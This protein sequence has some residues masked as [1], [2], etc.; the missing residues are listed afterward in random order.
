MR[1]AALSLLLVGCAS[2]PQIPANEFHITVYTQPPGALLYLT[3]SKQ[4]LGRAPQTRAYTLHTP[5]QTHTESITAVWRSGAI[6][7]MRILAT[8]SI[9]NG[10]V[11][12]SRPMHAPGLDK[13]MSTGG[14]GPAP[15]TVCRMINGF[16][17]CF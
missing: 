5:S 15:M 6:E 14:G 2:G 13:D 3:D 17:V 9:K 12:I 8:T 10:E 1:L 16:N 7:T 11:T 4:A